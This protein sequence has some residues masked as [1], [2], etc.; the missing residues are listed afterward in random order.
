MFT[1]KPKKVFEKIN[2][3]DRKQAYTIGA[4]AVVLVVALIMLISAAG[5]GDDDSFAGMN[6]R[7]YDLAQMPFAT[8]AAEQYLLANAYPDMQENGST[9]LYSAE[10]K[11]ERQEEDAQNAEEEEFS[12]E[13]EYNSSNSSSQGDS[14]NSG[15][16]GRGYGGYG[17]GRGSSKT[18]IGQLSGA[19]MAH[20]GGS[21]VNATWGPSGD[22]R[23]FKGREDRGN[24]RP[25]QLSTSDAR[26]SLAQFRSGSLAA[27]RINENKMKNAGKAVFGGEIKGSDAFGKDGVDLEKL[28]SGGLTLDTSA[29]SSTTDLSNLDKKVADAAKKAED[30]KKEEY[31]KEW[32][33]EMLIDLA[34]SAANTLVNAFMESVGDTIKGQV[35]GTSAYHSARRQA[36]NDVYAYVAAGKFNENNPYGMTQT[37]FNTY[38][39]AIDGGMK[40]G[41]FY[42]TYGKSNAYA[43]SQGGEARTEAIIGS[44][45]TVRATQPRNN[46]DNLSEGTVRDSAGK[47]CA[48]TAL[49]DG[50]CP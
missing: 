48:A 21:G 28:Q 38:R 25:A 16:S 43:S 7:G 29:P 4:I 5:S 3:M 8:D 40:P 44:A 30:K 45:G 1:F 34:K 37:D 18:E 23:Q 15:S 35:N 41:K 36:S 26:R 20:S 22:F 2:K 47:I 27:A 9:L 12:Q 17:G 46:N 13:D 39:T 49:Q 11:E 19:S 6:S 14:Y 32:W 42:R 10:E 31:K 24:E 50:K 33:E